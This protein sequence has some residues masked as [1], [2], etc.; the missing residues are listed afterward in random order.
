MSRSLRSN[1]TNSSPA[2]LSQSKASASFSP[3]TL[4][5]LKSA[6]DASF[7]KMNKM[8]NDTLEKS[9]EKLRIEISNDFQAQIASLESKIA[10]Q[11]EEIENLKSS[12]NHGN[13]ID[14][15][16]DSL[17]VASHELMRKAIEANIV[18]SGIP[19]DET[20][21]DDSG[22][23]GKVLRTLD[24]PLSEVTNFARVGKASDHRPRLLKI[25]FRSVGLRIKA[26]KNAR[27]LRQN[28]CF[29]RVF[30]NPDLTFA[31]RQEQKRLRD[32]AREIKS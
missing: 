18:V 31:E 22:L 13:K 5:D 1:S 11:A 32:K 17:A 16:L 12:F 24:C 29:Y 15:K 26:V 9:L 6:L 21:D 4:S 14:S 2:Q 30:V 23:I 10:S 28:S 25:S 20:I 3:V 27:L 7:V 19:E 8:F